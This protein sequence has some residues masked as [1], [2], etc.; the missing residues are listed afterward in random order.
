M[1]WKNNPIVYLTAKMWL[2][3]KGNR[4][5]VVL[6]FLFFI[7]GNAVLLLETMVVAFFLNIIQE[8][9]LTNETFPKLLGYLALIIV[10]NIIFWVFHG[11]ARVLENANAFIVRSQYKQY[12]LEGTMHLPVSWH[13]NNHSGDTIN[14]IEKGTNALFK[15]SADTFM[16]I[17]ALVR[18]FGSYLALIYFNINASYIVLIIVI[19]TI[20]IILKFDKVLIRQYE[21]LNH[22]DN[23]ISAKVYDSI[24]NIVTIIILRVEHP[25]LQMIAKKI[26][27]PFN[28]FVKNNKINEVKWFLVT[29]CSVL[30]VFSVIGSYLYSNL[31][32]GTVV[33][34]GTIYALYGYVDRI[35]G[36][37]YN[38]AYMY[39][40]IVQQKTAVQNAE[41]ISNEFKN[42]VITDE[43]ELG[44][45]WHELAIK[46]LK[47]SYHT[48]EGADLHLD[49]VALTIH[50]GE[51][52]ALVGASG[53][54]KTTLL[55][56][57]RGLYTPHGLAIAVDG[58]KLPHGFNSISSEIALIPQEPE[59]FA[60]T[61]KEN[62]TIGVDR[63]LHD[64]KIYTD[65][66]R[67]T[68]VAE[69][70]PKRFNS[71]IVE[72]GVNLSGGEKQRLALA[73]GLMACKDKAI[74]LLDEP[75]SSVDFRNETH[76]YEN[77]FSAFKDK[78]IISSIHRL[79]LLPLFDT[80][81]LLEGGK[82]IDSGTFQELTA[83]S[84][85]F[86]DVWNKYHSNIPSGITLTT[87]G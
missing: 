7:I 38:F 84:P 65:M 45:K 60:T 35:S 6:Y 55:K 29:M 40:D 41:E 75:T 17:Q 87:D 86:K 62:I 5:N 26:N 48:K 71:S 13:T 52:I 76:I 28:L 77:I 67:F 54:G 66:A 34:V 20:W 36:L 19:T 51:K 30:M 53:S 44:K 63:S 46:S 43:Y 33:A 69:R 61:V 9:G 85:T 50:R 80:I 16:L 31:I 78:A 58:K 22:A 4:R 74:V 83:H 37:F 68:E 23:S 73:R 57:I 15:F 21:E 42:K 18:V 2:F 12:L 24:S 72:K 82:I 49:N 56:I 59:I 64:I 1:S 10:I 32:A 11:P 3:S 47:F 14:K 39:S 81:Y 79:H 8:N 27:Q 25:I 70:L